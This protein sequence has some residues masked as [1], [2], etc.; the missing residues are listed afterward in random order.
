MLVGSCI[1][2]DRCISNQVFDNDTGQL[3]SETPTYNTQFYFLSDKVTTV[4]RLIV[5]LNNL[6]N[7]CAVDLNR[8]QNQENQQR[9]SA[10]QARQMC[11]A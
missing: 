8:Q 6:K 9:Q 1:G 2:G 3:T 7:K 11:E 5:Q 10:N 4:E